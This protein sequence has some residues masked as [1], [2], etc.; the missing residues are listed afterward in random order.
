MGN[1]QRT[2]QE[3]HEMYIRLFTRKK[4]TPTKKIADKKEERKNDDEV[5][6][7]GGK[8]TMKRKRSIRN[9]VEHVFVYSLY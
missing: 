3:C 6:I 5:T 1:R 4:R 2:A 8:G 9:L 7:V